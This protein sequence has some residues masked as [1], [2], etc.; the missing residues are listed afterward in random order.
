MGP[1]QDGENTQEAKNWGDVANIPEFKA[2]RKKRLLFTAQRGKRTRWTQKVDGCA[3]RL[4]PRHEQTLVGAMCMLALGERN[5]LT[6]DDWPPQS[7]AQLMR[8]TG[9][10]CRSVGC[11]LGARDLS[12]LLEQGLS[13]LDEAVLSQTGLHFPMVD[14]DTRSRALFRLESGQ[15]KLSSQ[16]AAAFVDAFLTLAANAYLREQTTSSGHFGKIH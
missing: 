8:G 12:T 15:L 6:A 7:I 10:Q 16:R 11:G 1:A 4:R 9:S 5:H 14:D 3:H 13:A 2:M